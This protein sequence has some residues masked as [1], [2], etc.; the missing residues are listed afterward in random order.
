MTDAAKE[1]WQQ[2]PLEE[3]KQLLKEL[4]ECMLSSQT[5][6]PR[7]MT[8]EDWSD[9][10]K[11]AFIGFYS[12]E[13]P[14]KQ[15]SVVVDL[16]GLAYRYAHRELRQSN[17]QF[18]IICGYFKRHLAHVQVGNKTLFRKCIMENYTMWLDIHLEAV[19]LWMFQRMD[20]V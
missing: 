20:S 9:L 10:K 11:G 5:N 3:K 16:E 6:L 14:H 13:P 4:F 15:F 18:A 8:N 7:F 2:L 19:Y 1:K 17:D 12:Y